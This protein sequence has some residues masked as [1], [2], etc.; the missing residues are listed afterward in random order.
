M[1]LDAPIL[2][3]ANSLWNNDR[4]RFGG[5]QCYSGFDTALDSGGFV[6]MM[7]YG[8]Y[9]WSVDQ[10]VSLAATMRPTWWAQ[11]DFCCEPEIASNQQEVRKRIDRTVEHLHQCQDATRGTVGMPM[12][13]L[14]GWKP[15]DYCEGPIWDDGFKWP[16]LVGVGSVCRRPLRG[17]TGIL[18]V[19]GALD[20]KLPESVQLHLFGVK[21]AALRALADRFPTRIASV[22]SMAWNVAA[23]REA[24]NKNIPCPGS[25]RADHMGS[26]YLKQVESLKTNQPTLNL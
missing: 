22:D 2:V 15:T 7:R 17:P 14:Q 8:G 3:S 10:Y 12:P 21:S 19:I 18:A 5:W 23:R 25:M 24:H 20:G 9:R 13:V 11:M 16:N 1:E 4:Q 6:A 26:W